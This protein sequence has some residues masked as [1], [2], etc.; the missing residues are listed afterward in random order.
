MFKTSFKSKYHQILVGSFYPS[1]DISGHLKA[2]PGPT[3]LKFLL[4]TS[5]SFVVF[6]VLWHQ[7]V[8][9]LGIFSA[10]M[11]RRPPQTCVFP[12]MLRHL[13]SSANFLSTQSA[14]QVL[15]G[16]CDRGHGAQT[17]HHHNLIPLC[18]ISNIMHCSTNNR[19]VGAG[20]GVLASLICILYVF[21]I[22]L[23]VQ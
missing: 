4:K 10:L 3:A 19:S 2:K 20:V 22:V 12:T 17:H 18:I 6:C 14:A 16:I 23:S 13:A 11:V 5:R 15:S 21:S 1:A 9:L 8:L 7:P